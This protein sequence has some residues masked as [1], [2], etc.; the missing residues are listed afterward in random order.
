MRAAGTR[1][2]TGLV[3]V[4][5][6]VAAAWA[7]SAARMGG[8]DAG[9]ASDLGSVSWFTATWLLMMTAMMLPSL[10]PALPA[11]ARAVAPF[12]AGYLVAWTAAGLAA[13]TLIEVVRALEPGFLAWDEAGRYVAGAVIAAAAF[14]ELTP[15]KEACLRRC[16]APLADVRPGRPPA[17]AL[18]IGMGHGV[19]CIGCCW[20]L[21][22][23]LFAL[24]AM[25][26]VWM[27]LVA[28]VVAAER[29]LPWRRMI[30]HSIALLLV[31]LGAAVALAPG[32]VPGFTEPH[33]RPSDHGMGAN[34]TR[35]PTRPGPDA[36][37]GDPLRGLALRVQIRDMRRALVS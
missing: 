13:Y 27:S 5:A 12:L 9:P 20:A 3:A 31:L 33:E 22:A 1:R 37:R 34:E 35:R 26:L 4:L 28:G 18:T 29:L 25:S 8:M 19:A 2:V 15:L 10:A 11:Q 24:G 6:L 32:F 17:A 36:W 16:R 30:G 7:L 23:A 14:Y 21:T